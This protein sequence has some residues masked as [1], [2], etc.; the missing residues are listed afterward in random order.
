M[1][2]IHRSALIGTAVLGFGIA[3]PASA[4]T[5]FSGAGQ[6]SEIDCDGG[7]VHVEGASNTL[8]IHGPCT[9]LIVEGADNRI[10]IDLAA[11]SSIAIE[12][13]SNQIR[14]TAPGKARPKLRITGAANSVTRAN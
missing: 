8:T 14:W 7:S 1:H 3:A 10:R 12:G 4:Q 2:I 11:Q 9:A 13:A 6:E 5:V